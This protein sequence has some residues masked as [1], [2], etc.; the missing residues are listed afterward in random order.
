MESFKVGDR[1]I[2]TKVNEAD[3]YDIKLMVGNSYKIIQVHDK[4]NDY[5]HIYQVEDH[6]G[7]TVD[8]KP[9]ELIRDR[10]P[11]LGLI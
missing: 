1:V 11:M 2:V 8:F 3:D 7:N 6:E 10:K 9:S 4:F 5:E